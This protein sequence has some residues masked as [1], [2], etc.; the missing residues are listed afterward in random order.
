MPHER[1]LDAILVE[2]ELRAPRF[3]GELVSIYLGG[4]TPSLWRPDCV[5]RAIS[6]IRSQVRL[7][8]WLR[9]LSVR[10]HKSVTW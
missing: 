6:A 7:S 2:L 10:R 9:R 8:F 4:G 5:A 3:A 1:Y